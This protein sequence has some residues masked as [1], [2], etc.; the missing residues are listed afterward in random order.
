[1][2]HAATVS[3]NLIF[4]SNI[5]QTKELLHCECYFWLPSQL[6]SCTTGKLRLCGSS[7]CWTLASHRGGPFSILGDFMCDSLWKRWHFSRFFS[8]FFRFPLTLIIPPSLHTHPLCP[9]KCAIVLTGS[10]LSHARSLS[11]SLHV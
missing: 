9:L 10:T 6:L 4:H 7:G 8:Y 3:L 11:W 1:M 2:T 5:D